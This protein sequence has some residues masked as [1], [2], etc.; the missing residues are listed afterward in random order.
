M[1]IDLIRQRHDYKSGFTEFIRV[2][3]GYHAVLMCRT[4]VLC[5]TTE[6]IM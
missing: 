2:I 1:Y 6:N 4:I 5:M 3:P